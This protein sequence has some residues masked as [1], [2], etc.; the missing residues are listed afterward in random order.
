[1][2]NTNGLS[3]E[4][5]ASDKNVL[6]EESAKKKIDSS[7]VITA[8][9]KTTSAAVNSKLVTVLPELNV[10]NVKICYDSLS[11]ELIYF[12]VDKKQETN[13]TTT[14][15]SSSSSETVSP[16]SSST[17]TTTFPSPSPTSDAIESTNQLD[18]TQKE[19]KGTVA[20]C[21]FIIDHFEKVSIIYCCRKT[22]SIKDET[23]L[24]EYYC[25]ISFS[26]ASCNIDY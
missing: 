6:D 18:K 3:N 7:S 10:F 15:T 21:T 17:A 20:L 8:I 5:D 22:L 19:V 14:L 13:K 24:I 4:T 9:P 25:I 2:Q 16:P 12:S 1:M 26:I 23:S 11:S